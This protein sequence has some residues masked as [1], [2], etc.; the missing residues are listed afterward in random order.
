MEE[1]SIPPWPD[2]FCSSH[3]YLWWV[4]PCVFF[5]LKEFAL[6]SP[7]KSSTKEAEGKETTAEEELDSEVLEVFHPT[8]EWQALQPG[9]KPSPFHVKH[10]LNSKC[11]CPLCPQGCF[12]GAATLA[13]WRGT[14]WSFRVMVVAS[15]LRDFHFLAEQ[16]LR[17]VSALKGRKVVGG[18]AF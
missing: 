17:H 6:T 5:S 4:M 15:G 13:H 3:V 1:K 18:R 11:I 7:E 16:R 8:H 14:V 12:E 2:S 9:T 10:T